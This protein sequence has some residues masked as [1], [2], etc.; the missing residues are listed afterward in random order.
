M[1]V[2]SVCLLTT[3]GYELWWVHVDTHYVVG[4]GCV[5]VYTNASL[6]QILSTTE[7]LH[8]H[9]SDQGGVLRIVFP[10]L[11][12]FSQFLPP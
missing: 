5:P 8:T 9:Q 11:H 10:K 7:H 2:C 6:Y 3:N 4:G 12:T 1:L